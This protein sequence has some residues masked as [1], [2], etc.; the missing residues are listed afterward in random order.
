MP[1]IERWQAAQAGRHEVRL[2]D[3]A[4]DLGAGDFLFL[5][6][7]QEK[8]S[9]EIRAR[10]RHCLVCHES[11]LPQG[12]GWS[13]VVWQVLEG[14]DRIPVTLLEAEDRI[15]AGR[16]WHQVW[17]ALDGTELASEVNRR[18][19]EATIAL[20][21]WAVANEETVTPREQVGTPSFYRRRTPADSE[22]SPDATLAEA[23]D[24]L[25]IADELRYPAFVQIRGKRYR[26]RLDVMGDEQAPESDR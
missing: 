17:I 10:F 18:V 7:C 13:P 20:V 1:H 4:A 12:R 21:D 16:I 2:V 9:G 6:A 8:V 3:S 22:V 25:R 24:L 23:F 15:D 26:I 14:R 19:A 5:I 11:D